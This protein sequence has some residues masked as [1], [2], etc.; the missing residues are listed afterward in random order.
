MRT[1]LAVALVVVI[2]IIWWGVVLWGAEREW[3]WPA[4]RE[5]EGEEEECRS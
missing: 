2:T 5:E 1:I 4:R 3:D